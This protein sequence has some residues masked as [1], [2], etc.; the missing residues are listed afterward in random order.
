MENLQEN[1]TVS[2]FIFAGIVSGI[3]VGWRG[4]FCKWIAGAVLQATQIQPGDIF[5]FQY[6]IPWIKSF[7]AVSFTVQTGDKF[8]HIV[9]YRD[10]LVSR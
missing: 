7:G 1:I 10:F 4:L 3:I 2:W 5:E 8:H 6:G 9:A